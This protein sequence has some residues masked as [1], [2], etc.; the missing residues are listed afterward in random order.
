[1]MKFLSAITAIF[2][3]TLFTACDQ[4][5]KAPMTMLAD[6]PP[7]IHDPAQYNKLT[8]EEQRIIKFQCTERPFTG[9]YAENHE[10]GVYICR[11]CN[12]PLFTSESKFDS[13]SG[14]P[15]FDEFIP[16]SV[17]EKPDAD[18]SRTEI[19]CA[20]CGGHIGHVFMGEGFTDKN[21]R[22]CA[23]SASLTF[24]PAKAMKK[25]DTDVQ[26]INEYIKGKGLENYSKATFAGGCF[27]CSEAS[28]DRI[29][30]VVA[31]ISGYT[32][33][34]EQ[35]PTYDEVSA[36]Q[37][38]HAEAVMV[39]FDPKIVSY[40]KLLEVFFVAHNPTEL[41]RQGPDVGEQ[42]RSA[43]FYQ[44]EEQK[45]LAEAYIQHLTEIK[46]YSDPIVTEVSPYKEF[47]VAEGYHQDYYDLHP[48]QPYIQHVS[49][50][51]VEKVQKT[52]PDIIKKVN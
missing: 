7:V 39:Y 49:K 8:P 14:W 27:W 5:G 22:H 42:Y 35:Y 36:H 46:K 25:K 38:H 50:P 6:L 31:V 17:R 34:D 26:P 44:N 24:V 10:A 41:N 20:N 52:F 21:T 2:T 37:T 28:F 19:V 40:E 15:S 16:G 18:G 47:W 23:N 43:I 51:K 29:N 30:G 33:G 9:E 1:M 4:K 11:Q 13:G 32:G 48:D 12:N 45:K 3:L